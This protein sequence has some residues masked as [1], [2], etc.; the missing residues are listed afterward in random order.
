[1][2]GMLSTNLFATHLNKKCPHYCSRERMGQ[3][4]LGDTFSGTGIF[5]MPSLHFPT[6][7]GPA[8]N[9]K[10]RSSC[11]SDCSYLAETDLVPLPVTAWD[12]PP[13]LSPSHSLPPLA[14][15]RT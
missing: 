5:F 14:E 6:V 15:Q 11:H 3:H 10:G 2:M 12:V 1:M 4:S 8:E 7:K 13:D 9:K